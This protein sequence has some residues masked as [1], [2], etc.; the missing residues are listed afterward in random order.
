[1]HSS[2]ERTRPHS[3]KLKGVKRRHQ[4]HSAEEWQDLPEAKVKNKASNRHPWASVSSSPRV[5]TQRKHAFQS[6]LHNS[7]QQSFLW[8]QHGLFTAAQLLVLST[9]NS[10]LYVFPPQSASCTVFSHLEA[11][12]IINTNTHEYIRL[13]QQ[14]IQHHWIQTQRKRSAQRHSQRT[15]L[16][17]VQPEWTRSLRS[18]VGRLCQSV[19][20]T[21]QRLLRTR[22]S[23]RSIPLTPRHLH[24]RQSQWALVC[25]TSLRRCR[26]CQHPQRP[27]SSTG[28]S[29]RPHLWHLLDWGKRRPDDFGLR[30]FDQI[31][32]HWRAKQPTDDNRSPAEDSDLQFRLPLASHRVSL[33]HDPHLQPKKPT[34]HQQADNQRLPQMQHIA[35]LQVHVL[36]DNRSKQIRSAGHHR[37]PRLFSRT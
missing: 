18:I 31:L 29:R 4:W 15:S 28:K 30:Q 11:N 33:N 3:L 37:R 5:A 34:K 27:K 8:R 6:R 2:W 22:E 9:L 13:Q 25:R 20:R 26:G 32:G 35:I 12:S 19:R 17:Q 1:M 7:L 36:F 23:A 14:P 21:Q 10:S 16:G 24:R